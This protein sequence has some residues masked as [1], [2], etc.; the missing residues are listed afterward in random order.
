MQGGRGTEKQGVRRQEAGGRK[1]KGRESGI[2]NRERQKQGDRR[3]EAGG[4]KTLKPVMRE[5]GR[6]TAKPDTTKP[7]TAKPDT[8]KPDT[9]KPDTTKPDTKQGGGGSRPPAL[10]FSEKTKCVRIPTIL[11]RDCG[12]KKM[13]E[14]L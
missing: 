9:A 13:L 4:R 7:D 6:A 1:G 3:Q 12:L 2:V 5:A 11:D 14:A 8:T 10:L